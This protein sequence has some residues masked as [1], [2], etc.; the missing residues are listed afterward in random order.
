MKPIVAIV[1]RPNVGKS[2]LF[3]RL[4]GK[5]EAIVEKVSGVTRDR[6]YADA[7]W[8]GAAFTLIDTGGYV[9]QSDDVFE[10]AIR[11]QVMISIEQATAIIFV[12]DAST[13]L[14]PI[15]EEIA[16]IIRKSNKPFILAVNKCDAPEHEAAISIFYALGL[17]EP[18]PIAAMS[19]RRVGDFLDILCAMFPRVDA[20]E[21][22]SEQLHLA[23]IGKPNVGKSSLV[24]ALLGENRHIVTDIAGTTRDSIDSIA[25]YHSEKIVLIDTAGL[26]K[27]KYVHES[28]EYYSTIRTI[29]SIDRCDV[30]AVLFD[31]TIGL[32]KQD[33]IIVN[34]IVEKKK[35]VFIVMNKWDLIEKETKT[36]H[37]I[38]SSI[39]EKLKLLDYVPVIFISALTHQ[40]TSSVLKLAKEIYEERKKRISTNKLNEVLLPVVESHPP[41][42]KQ[43]KDIR[44]KYITQVRANP[45]VFSFFTNFPELMQEQY[46]RYIENTL[47]E[48]FGFKGVPVTIVFKKK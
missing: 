39:Y 14:L 17:G 35:G 22:E 18:I 6:H 5:R 33:A 43:G 26:R 41:S 1:G 8:A 24:N 45:P 11:E 38:E 34:E 40:R 29:R 12:V 4:L 37:E 23:I 32:Q 16:A 10:R 31:A 2:T 28:V 48:H 46:K 3:N 21:E 9:P 25:T 44:I 7:E 13:G 20:L 19:G 36:A 15:D 42:S 27:R 47:R 30:A